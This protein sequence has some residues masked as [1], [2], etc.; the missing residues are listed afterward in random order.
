MFT[1]FLSSLLIASW[2]SG[3]ANVTIHK[4]WHLQSLASYL[5]VLTTKE[6]S[7][8]RISRVPYLKTSFLIWCLRF[9][10]NVLL[11]ICPLL[12]CR[13]ES[14]Y[15]EK[16]YILIFTLFLSWLL[17]AMLHC[18]RSNGQIHETWHVTIYFWLYQ[19]IYLSV[20]YGIF[21]QL[22]PYGSIPED[23]ASFCSSCTF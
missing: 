12:S 18:G 21:S 14:N 11:S 23:Q 15:V 19:P 20:Q 2:Q 13:L 5:C 3:K 9:L 17:I 1:L 16:C 4:N 6:Y 7:R 10:F 8:C 22:T